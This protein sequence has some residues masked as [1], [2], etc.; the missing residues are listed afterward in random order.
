MW[1]TSVFECVQKRKKF[2]FES[3][4]VMFSICYKIRSDDKYTMVVTYAT[5][6]D[7]YS[8]SVVIFN[9]IQGHLALKTKDQLISFN[10]LCQPNLAEITMKF[11]TMIKCYSFKT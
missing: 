6:T 11:Y 10:E 1:E 3:D 8:Q 2:Y 5:D 7:C 9:K 4:T